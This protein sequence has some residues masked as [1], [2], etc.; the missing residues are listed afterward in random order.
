MLPSATLVRFF[1]LYYEHVGE[2]A[3]C[4]DLSTNMPENWV[5]LMLDMITILFGEGITA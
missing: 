3:C 2:V 1:H 4:A 5:Q